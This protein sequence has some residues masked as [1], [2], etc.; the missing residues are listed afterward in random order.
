MRTN[1]LP[2]MARTASVPQGKSALTR[3]ASTEELG[4]AAQ[5]NPGPECT[6]ACSPGNIALTF[7]VQPFAVLPDTMH[8]ASWAHLELLLPLRSYLQHKLTV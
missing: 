8:V 4:T 5:V 6:H 3:A 1:S 2:G 7:G